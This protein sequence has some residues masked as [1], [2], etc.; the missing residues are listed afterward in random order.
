[1]RFGGRHRTPSHFDLFKNLMLL[2]DYKSHQLQHGLPFNRDA[3][4]LQ[5]V[6]TKQN[7]SQA[8]SKESI[9]PFPCASQPEESKQFLG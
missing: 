9:L 5:I 1:M 2:K 6:H 4:Q 8:T 7:T 3:E